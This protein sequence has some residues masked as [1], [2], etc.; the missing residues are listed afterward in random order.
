MSTRKVKSKAIRAG[1]DWSIRI[2]FAGSSV[3]FPSTATFVA[4]VRRDPTA[5]DILATMTTA[6]LGVQRVDTN[7]IDLVLAGYKTVNWPERTAYIDVVRTDGG[8][9]HLGFSLAVPVILP[10][11]RGVS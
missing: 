4:Q 9:Q 1:Y 8:I 7:T 6:D 2:N 10:I 5:T 3:S 11:T